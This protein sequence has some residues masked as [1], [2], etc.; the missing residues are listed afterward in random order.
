MRVRPDWSRQRGLHLDALAVSGYFSLDVMTTRLESPRRATTEVVTPNAR[1]YCLIT[2]CRD[3]ATFARRTIESVA[4]QSIPP[5]L[6][7][8]VDD[9]SRDETANI[10]EEAASRLP[11]LRLIRRRDRGSRKV[12]A[13]V[14]EAFNEGYATIDP[15]Q[16]E[17]LCKFDLDL[18]VPP[19]YFEDLMLR[20][21]AEPRLGT[22]SG[23]PW[24]LHPKTGKLL[25]EYCGDDTSVGPTKFYRTACFQEMGG[26]VAEVM[27]DGIDCHRCRQLGWIAESVNDERL[28]FIHLRPMGSS[29]KG[30][31]TGRTRAGFGQYYMGTSPTYYLASAAYRL[32]KH[33]PVIGS[34]AMLWGYARSALLGLP[35]YGDREFR[36]FL[37][38]YQ[39]MCLLTGKAS[40][41]ATLNQR[42][43]AVWHRR[44]PASS[45]GAPETRR[46]S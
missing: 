21:E 41:V 33:P 26:F 31:W 29:H 28:R 30:L 45:A 3:E 46:A 24:F 20:M 15:T 9:G 36:T 12:G 27:W 32:F 37:R 10:V 2:P 23:K 44:H 39:R 22:C 8:V 35:R 5:A 25:P 4:R 18:E 16:L 34:L 17:Y 11:Y 7:V 42:Q 38:R 40:A 14:I 19:N 1:R 13:G 6:W 43:A